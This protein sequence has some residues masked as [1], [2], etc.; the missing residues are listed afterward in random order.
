MKVYKH[1]MNVL[2]NK[3]M[4]SLLKILQEYQPLISKFSLDPKTGRL[5]EDL[6][7]YIYLNL[8]QRI[9]NFKIYYDSINNF[10]SKDVNT[11]D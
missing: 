3:D 11:E 7:S 1:L 2:D 8:I 4:D 10:A 6:Q 5:N 9:P